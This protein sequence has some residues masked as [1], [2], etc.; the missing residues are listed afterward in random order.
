MFKMLR[1]AQTL[2]EFWPLR[3]CSQPSRRCLCHIPA[4][5]ATLFVCVF[6]AVGRH[7]VCEFSFHTVA[8]CDMKSGNLLKFAQAK[9]ICSADLLSNGCKFAFLAYTTKN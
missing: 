7:S 1:L 2:T 4:N 9:G 6:C 5:L 3:Q 8:F